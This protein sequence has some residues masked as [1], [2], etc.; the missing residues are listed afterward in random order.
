MLIQ[1]HARKGIENRTNAGHHCGHIGSSRRTRRSNGLGNSRPGLR[2]LGRLKSLN[3][4][5]RQNILQNFR[6][7]GRIFL[8]G[9]NVGHFGKLP[10]GAC[11]PNLS[12]WNQRR[13]SQSGRSNNGC[14]SIQ[15]QPSQ[16]LTGTGNPRL[17]YQDRTVSGNV[18][19]DAQLNRRTQIFR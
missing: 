8:Q 10:H 12:G 1:G 18:S 19:A 5:G 16:S 6:L 4:H 7:T 3:I 13:L 17:R 9:R 2:L 15:R 11:R 14:G